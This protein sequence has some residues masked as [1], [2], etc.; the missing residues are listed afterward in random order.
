MSKNKVKKWISSFDEIRT[1]G[2][3]GNADVYLVYIQCLSPAKKYKLYKSS[4]NK[5][6]HFMQRIL[7]SS[8]RGQRVI[9][10]LN[11]SRE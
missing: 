8:P 5:S 10:Q 2:T 1:L 7:S 6:L 3:G 9:A 11:L 4:I